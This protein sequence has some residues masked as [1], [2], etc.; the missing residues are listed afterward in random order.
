MSGAGMSVR[1]I[2]RRPAPPPGRD[3]ETRVQGDKLSLT[4]GRDNVTLSAWSW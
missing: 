4:P 2:L 3:E 1:V